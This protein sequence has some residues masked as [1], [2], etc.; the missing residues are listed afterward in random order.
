M[1]RAWWLIVLLV[2]MKCLSAVVCCRD[3]VDVLFSDEYVTNVTY[4]NNPNSHTNKHCLRSCRVVVVVFDPSKMVDNDYSFNYHIGCWLNYTNTTSYIVLLSIGDI[5]DFVKE[6]LEYSKKRYHTLTTKMPKL[7]HL[8][9]DV[10][11]YTTDAPY[12]T[13]PPTP[14]TCALH[15]FGLATIIPHAS[16]HLTVFNHAWLFNLEQLSNNTHILRTGAVTSEYWEHINDRVD[17]ENINDILEALG[18]VFKKND[19]YHH[20][21]HLPFFHELEDAP[22]LTM[23]P[24]V[25]GAVTKH[26]PPLID[27]IKYVSG[28]TQHFIP[29][30]NC[31]IAVLK[32]GFKEPIV[33]VFNI[34][35]DSLRV[36][37]YYDTDN[38]K[39]WKVANSRMN[40]FIDMMTLPYLKVAC[41]YC[42]RCDRSPMIRTYDSRC[43]R[44]HI[45]HP[46]KQ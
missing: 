13:E 3:P 19:V 21:D 37:A 32:F 18:L 23:G 25:Y 8:C 22:S 34:A 45:L 24:G 30:K 43:T 39:E 4:L 14:D 9:V 2:A 40:D 20:I 42:A 29:T 36:D 17:V 16:G 1:K 11:S 15:R 7:Q 38:E 31:V 26:P 27:V 28:F 12:N 44:T 46:F 10:S 33:V 41:P 35:E 5:P 6:Q